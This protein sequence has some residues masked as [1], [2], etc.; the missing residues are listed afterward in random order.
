MSET[1]LTPLGSTATTPPRMRPRPCKRCAALARQ[2]KKACR[3]WLGAGGRRVGKTQFGKNRLEP[4]VVT[5]RIETS[6]P[7]PGRE[8]AAVLVRIYFQLVQ[9]A[10]TFTQRYEIE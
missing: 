2:R 8:T 4:W 5:Q 3:S 7:E 6:I 9:G 1:R 10:A